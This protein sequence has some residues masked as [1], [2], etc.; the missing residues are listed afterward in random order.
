MPL[1]TEWSGL[2]PNEQRQFIYIIIAVVVSLVLLLALL[3]VYISGLKKLAAKLGKKH[4]SA[5]T[6][7]KSQFAQKNKKKTLKQSF[8]VYLK[9]SP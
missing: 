4:R 3:T 8:N 5:L 1:L 7:K 9:R 6:G 2:A